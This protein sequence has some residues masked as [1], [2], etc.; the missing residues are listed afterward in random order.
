MAAAGRKEGRS[1]DQLGEIRATRRLLGVQLLLAKR[2][3]EA[4]T[5]WRA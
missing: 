3:G 1:G 4:A 5:C 2:L